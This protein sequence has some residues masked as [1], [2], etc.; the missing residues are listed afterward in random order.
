MYEM[1]ITGNAFLYHQIR[2]IAGVLFL[3]GNGLEQPQVGVAVNNHGLLP[4]VLIYDY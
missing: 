3:I 1:T 4:G 2:C